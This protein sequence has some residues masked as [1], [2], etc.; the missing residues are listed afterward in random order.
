MT[1]G[2]VIPCFRQERWLHRTIAALER[3]LAGREWRGALVIAGPGDPVPA[4][5]DRW[6]V[7]APPS[8]APL[9]PGA[10]RM[11]GFSACG[12]ECVLFVDADVAV[13]PAWVERA[14]GVMELAAG[15]GEPLAGVFGRLEEWFEDRGA[16][17]PGSRD[18]YRVG[19]ADRDVPYL[20]T[21]ALYSREALTEAGGYDARLQS[22]ED[23][24]LGL[25]VRRTGRRLRSLAPLAGRHWSAPRPSFAELG[26]RWSAGLCFG[27][28]QVL[29]LYIGRPGFGALLRRQRLYLA[30]LLMWALGL[31]ALLAGPLAGRTRPF[32]VWLAMP[33][34]VIALMTIRKRSLKL[35][36]HSLLT[37]SLNGAGMVVG[38]F[39]TAPRAGRG[40]EARC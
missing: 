24:E 18:L 13:E 25:R 29:R 20:A 40:A 2:V 3:A 7:I 8:A 21:L 33:L 12:G 27:Q 38:L 32:L 16:E 28:G 34:A 19:D 22:E 4:L 37:W 26:R 39:R 36:L 9:T 5:S 31:A 15:A 30:T 14:L 6:R 10:A 17:R 23:F 35:A 11:L 1:V